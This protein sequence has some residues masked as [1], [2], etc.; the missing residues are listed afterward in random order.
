MP[1]T[2]GLGL[3]LLLAGLAVGS[4]AALSGVGLIVTHR[5]TGVLNLAQGAQAMLIAYLLRELVVVRHWPLALAAVCCLLI[6][7]PALGVLLEAAVFR[8]LLRRGAGPAETLV[9]SVGVFVLLIGTAVLVWGTTPFGDAPALAP[10]TVLARP[11]GHPLRLDTLT[12]L[13]GVLLLTAAIGLADRYTGLG[14][15]LRAVV[16]DRRLAALTGIDADRV[17]AFGWAFGSFTAGLVGVLL[18]P[19][20]LLDPYGLPLLVLETMAVAV[21]ARLRSLPVA[22][23]TGLALGVVQS[24]LTR[25]RPPGQLLPL[26]QALQANLFVVALLVAALLPWRTAL[27][28]D[29]GLPVPYGRTTSAGVRAACLVLLLLPLWFRADDLRHALA[30]PALA[31][32][33]LSTVVVTGYG[34]QVSL[35]QAGYAG[36][37]ALGTAL[38]VSGRV[39]GLP[40]LPAVPALLLAVTAAVPLGLLTGWPAI[41]RR[42]LALALTTLAVGTALS[43]LVFDQPYATTGLDLGRTAL[44]GGDR[45]LYAV[46]L[47]LLGAALLLVRNLHRGRLGRALTALR[48]QQSAASAAGVDVPRLKL[49]LFMTGAGLAALGGALTT[50]ASH[51]FD[52]NAFDPVRGLLW[53]AAAVVAGVDSAAGAVAAAA[54]LTTLDTLAGQ[55]VSAVVVGVGAVAIGRLPGGLAGLAGRRR[56]PPRPVL[57]P[58][59]RR[60]RAR[61]TGG[62][63]G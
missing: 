50:L 27:A 21:A 13:A 28:A 34:G 18:A 22:V 12:Q 44:P 4:A 61:L 39:P 43:R 5:A 10:A 40:A 19:Y 46:E 35:G 33:L 24:E 57:G 2:L 37:G 17:S 38:L 54:A 20:L 8:P 14:V 3:D 48:D 55:G 53:F 25:W 49:L 36:L 15:R 41:R 47:L 58:L 63:A 9:A 23:A 56:R 30:V 11:G 42:G 52:P 29:R 6:A 7:A 31:L 26:A 60:V 51:S 59:G 16:D 1:D 32:V 62:G 45:G